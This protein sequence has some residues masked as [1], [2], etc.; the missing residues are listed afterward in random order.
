M[1]CDILGKL[2]NT[3]NFVS[4]PPR[5]HLTKKTGKNRL[6]NVWKNPPIIFKLDKYE[7]HHVTL[8]LQLQNY[9]NFYLKVS[10]GI[11]V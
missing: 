5:V 9:Q 3:D 8:Q 4:F 2:G 6:L 7:V 10:Q 11:D 1:Q